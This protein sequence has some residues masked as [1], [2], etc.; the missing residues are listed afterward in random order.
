VTL[1]ASP[2]GE[3]GKIFGLG[4]MGFLGSVLEIEAVAFPARNQ[5]QGSLRF[6]DTAGS[7]AKDSVFNATS[8]IRKLTGEDL[9]NYDLHINVVGGGRIDGP[10]AGVAIFLALLSAVQG[11]PI[12]QDIAVTG[13][14]SIQGKVRAVGGVYEKIYGARQAGIRTVLIPAENEKDV[15]ADLK[16]IRVIPVKTVEEVVRNMFPPVDAERWLV[17][18]L[19]YNQGL[20]RRLGQG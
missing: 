16:G 11:S 12:A 17:S 6:N 9:S 2:G 5:G 19:S 1:K 20:L 3:I 4:V 15:P 8:V 13:E 18:S 10:S 14:V 7:M